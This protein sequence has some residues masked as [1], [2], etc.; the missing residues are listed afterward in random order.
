LAFGFAVFLVAFWA[1]AALALGFAV[2]FES[3]GAAAL[4]FGFVDCF[5]A[6]FAFGEALR[7]VTL[8]GRFLAAAIAAPEIAPIAVPTIGMPDAVPAT[9]PPKVLLAVFES[10]SVAPLSLSSVHVSLPKLREMTL[11]FVSL[12]V[13]KPYGRVYRDTP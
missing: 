3:F 5:L 7:R 12:A 9:A 13:N 1:F 4:A 6:V 11:A 2:F 10:V 8:A